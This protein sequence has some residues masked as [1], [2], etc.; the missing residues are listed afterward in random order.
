M[1]DTITTYLIL[2]GGKMQIASNEIRTRV[3]GFKVQ[4]ADHYTMEA[5]LKSCPGDSH[6]FGFHGMSLYQNGAE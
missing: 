3:I 2:L 1:C 4:C 6:P 5:K